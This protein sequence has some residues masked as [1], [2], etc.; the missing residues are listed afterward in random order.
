M[1]LK[2]KQRN[3]KEV[4]SD[5]TSAMLDWLGVT[6]WGVRRATLVGLCVDEK[7]LTLRKQE[8]LAGL[9]NAASFMLQ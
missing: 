4:N 7:L 5:E 1:E 9:K 6:S 8:I 2:D 3:M